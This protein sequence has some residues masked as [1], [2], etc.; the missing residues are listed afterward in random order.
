MNAA[1]NWSMSGVRPLLIL[2]SVLL[3]LWP[4]L[5]TSA[6]EMR[7][8]TIVG[9]YA[10]LALGYQFI[11][12]HSGALALT[13]GTF[14]GVGAYVTGVLGV[15]YQLGGEFTVLLS[16]ALPLALAAL[17]A[18]PV[19]RLESHYFALATLGVGQ[20]VVLVVVAWQELTG[21]AN[22]LSGIPGL[23]LFGFEV[24]KGYGTM[25]AVWACVAA[26][27]FLSWRVT[28]GLYGAALH[29]SRE[30]PIA[31]LSVGIDTAKLRY[32]MFLFS[33]MFAGLAGALYAHTL[34]VVSPEA[35]E[36]PIMVACLT[37]TVV[38]G[39]T[40][41]AGAILGALLIVNLPEWFRAMEKYYLIAYGLA[42]L[43]MIIA[44]PYGLIGLLEQWRAKLWPETPRTLPKAEPLRN[45]RA[46]ERGSGPLLEIRDVHKRFGGL[47]ALNG[48]TLTVAQGEIFG[49]IGPNGSGKTTLLNVITGIYR[50][51]SGGVSLDGVGIHAKPSFAIAQSGIARTFQNINLVDEM[52]VLDNVA[53]A[54][55]GFENAGLAQTVAAG[56]NDPA[57]QRA[58]AQ[59]IHLLDALGVAGIAQS[60]AGSLAYGLKRKVEIARALA[61]EPKLL[62]LDEPAAGLNESEQ[63]DL[64]QRLRAFAKGGLAILVIEHNMPFLMPLAE[65]MA[66]LDHGDLIAVGA[67]ADIRANP[68]VVEAY[69]G[70]PE[71]T[72]A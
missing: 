37:I 28:R 40:H 20:V 11:F 23:T 60:A 53:V 51:D 59:A 61:L 41:I 52:S 35:L 64:A 10:L 14:F 65:R 34:R 63:L 58:R 50:A 69:L 68:L 31:A 67:P 49:L 38:G 16:I 26:G 27:A 21:G 8:F 54:R 19:L 22:G 47:K 3:A 46:V 29:I 62:L 32:A 17:I 44:A 15:K 55:Y 7:I 13:Q 12:G 42:L 56:W 43:A 45:S 4:M 1:L 2:G 6:Y 36:F 5:M 39:R 57:W 30:N 9:I 25:A 48:I 18:A 71:K 24:T 33:A 70:S 72:S 66:C